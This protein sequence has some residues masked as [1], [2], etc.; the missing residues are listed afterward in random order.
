MSTRGGR[1]ADGAVR[2]TEDYEKDHGV[3]APKILDT[4]EEDGDEW[5][6]SD[7]FDPAVAHGEDERDNHEEA[8]ECVEAD[9]R[10]NGLWEVSGRIFDLFGHVNRSVVADGD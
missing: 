9:G 5:I 6:A 8:Q 3:R 2:Q 10:Q 4:V 1:F 7:V